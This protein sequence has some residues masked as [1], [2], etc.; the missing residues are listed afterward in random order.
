ML[1]SL[2][3]E[4]AIGLG[5]G[6]GFGLVWWQQVTAPTAKKIKDYYDGK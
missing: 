5:L 6:V 4:A 1:N 3:R 2:L